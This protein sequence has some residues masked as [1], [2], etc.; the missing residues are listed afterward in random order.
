MLSR[1]RIL[2]ALLLLALPLTATAQTVYTWTAGGA[3]T[4]WNT[5]ANWNPAGGP[6]GTAATD[7]AVFNP[8]GGTT[9]NPQFT[10]SPTIQSLVVGPNRVGGG[11]TF[12]QDATQRTLS[13]G[14]STVGLTTTGPA[15]YTF[16]GPNL[17]GASATNTL[18]LNVGN[19]STLVLA[20]TSAV[21]ANQGNVTIQGGTLRLDNTSTNVPVR[22]LS[23][24]TVTINGGGMFELVGNSS[25]TTTNVGTLN[26]G[27]NSVGGVN[28]IRVNN[29]A[30][31]TVLNFANPGS[32]SLRPGT[33]GVYSFEAAV[34]NLGDTAAGGGRVTF[35]GTP[36]LG[37]N[38]L[39]AN[40]SGGGTVGFAIVRDAGGVDFATWNSTNGVV[41]ATPTQTG[42]TAANLQSYTAND[43]VQFDIATNQT[44]SATITNGSLR[45]TPGGVGL[46]LSMG[47]NNL[48]TNALM[49][50][51]ANDFSITG[52]GTLGGTGTRYIHVNNAGTTLSTSMLVANSSNP[53]VFAGPGFVE[54]TGTASQ[55]SLTGTNRFVVAGGVVRGNNTQIG[56]TS[57]GLGVIS[58]TG[59]VLEI[60]NGTNGTGSSADFTRA[61]GAAAGNVTWGGG[62]S[63][64]VG[65]GGFSAFGSNAS[66]N[67][68]GSATPTQVQWGVGNF[69]EN[70]YAL[71]FG[72]TK[73]DSTLTLY[74][75]IQLDATTQPAYVLREFN[76]TRGTGG[77]SDKTIL[78]GSLTT[79]G[80]AT[81]DILKTGNGVLELAASNTFVGNTVIRSG[82]LRVSGQ[83]GTNS[84]TSN[85][86]VLVMSGGTLGG[87]GQALPSSGNQISVLN[88][89]TIRGDSG[90]GTGT[91]TVG[92]TV[93]Q[94]GGILAVQHGSGTTASSLT[95]TSGS[96]LNLNSGAV[97]DPNGTIGGERVI[98]NLDSGAGALIVGGT[99]Y[100]SDATIATYTHAGGNT[101]LQA[102]GALQLD[103]TGLS[104][105]AG[106]V[107]QLRRNASNQL[108]FITP[109]PE[110]AFML[111][112]CGLVVGGVV[113]VR[114]LRRKA[115]PAAVTPAA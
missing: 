32:F 65:S 50:D 109:V 26:A 28:A 98:A 60:K 37:A 13:I 2:A 111:V 15:T 113:G 6:P 58:L 110:P 22:L 36:F 66:V 7:V 18:N 94:N 108:V 31:G 71:K 107:I 21:T 30:G 115:K 49:L 61:V 62:T 35:T 9:T 100:N 17:A 80:G 95:M 51:G 45:I 90:A 52:T 5:A 105:S 12:T 79:S 86:N 69:V 59:G 48:T 104:L 112:A 76:V 46:S 75:P 93:V 73:S 114:K 44:A 43:R 14:G 67:L 106:D 64:E 72:S 88:G 55:N 39:L 4:N 84:G 10:N 103:V 87:T 77:V 33:R 16:N 78:A 53:M 63:N 41:R 40:S 102:F 19:G 91:L 1:V 83:T 34:G 89:G 29:T 24:G 11:W 99:T 27:N 54:L 85:G 42:T 47:T 56:F 74:N 92:N 57:S 3:D 82:E 97:I 20:G 68:G 101:G 81:A 25:G 70:G 96:V 23:T 8:F 38:G